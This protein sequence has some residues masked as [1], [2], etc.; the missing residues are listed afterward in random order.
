MELYKRVAFEAA[1]LVTERYSTS[2]SLACKLFSPPM[3]RDIYGI[4]GLVRLADEIV[5]SYRGDDQLS[6]LNGLEADSY[7]SLKTGYSSNL[8]VHAFTDV[9]R[10]NGIDSELIKPFFASMRKDIVQTSY[11]STELEDYIYGSA[12]VVGLMCLRVFV[13]GDEARY[14]KL[15]PGAQALGAAFQKVNFLR[16]LASDHNQLGRNYFTGVDWD[17]F[18]N[19]AKVAIEQAILADFALAAIAIAEL[20][21]EA[22]PA[23]LAAYHYYRELLSRIQHTGASSLKSRRLRVSDG[24]KFW[25]LTKAWLGGLAAGVGL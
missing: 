17:N 21:R 22:R 12:E 20:P 25:I 10:R 7:A 23:V 14:S 6:I 2:F 18:D 5:D 9:A 24:T 15:K 1:E 13:A 8:I 3:R 11:S 19:S 4:Y 16:D